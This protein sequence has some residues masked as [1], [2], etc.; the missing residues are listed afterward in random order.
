MALRSQLMPI[1]LLIVASIIGSFVSGPGLPTALME[2]RLP[3][4]LL[5]VV[6]LGYLQL[7]V[8]LSRTGSRGRTTGRRGGAA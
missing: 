4:V 3:L 8:Q 5:L 2:V 7:Q 1:I 6:A